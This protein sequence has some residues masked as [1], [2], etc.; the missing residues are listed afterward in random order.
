MFGMIMAMLKEMSYR[1]GFKHAST[2][3]VDATFKFMLKS[4]NI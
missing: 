1:F 2:K 3:P 4:M